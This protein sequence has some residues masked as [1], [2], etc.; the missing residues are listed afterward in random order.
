MFYDYKVELYEKNG[1]KINE[2]GILADEE[3]TLVKT[4]KCDLQ[5]SSREILKRTYGIFKVRD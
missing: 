4:L 3:L 1:G 2:Y 5:P